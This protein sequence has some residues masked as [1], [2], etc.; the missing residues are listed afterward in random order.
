MDN[1]NVVDIPKMIQEYFWFRYL[2]ESTYKTYLMIGHLLN[3]EIRGEQ[4]SE[5]LMTAS[6][7]IEY[8]VGIM[9]EEKEKM[10]VKLGR[11][12]PE[13]RFED[14]NLLLSYN[15][16]SILNDEEENLVYVYNMPLP[17]PE[18]VLALDEEEI[19]TLNDIRFEFKHQ[20]VFNKILTLLIN[21]NGKVATSLDHI[22]NTTGA[23]HSD[24]KVVLQYLLEE[25]SIKIVAEKEVSE[26]RK[27]D[28][29]YID[30][31]KE[32]F[33]EKRFVIE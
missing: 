1:T 7:D 24:I 15:L 14:L 17:R 5:M 27:S 33:E 11:K 30:I 20:D 2:P 32:I 26:L 18:D 16:I 31:V 6:F 21:S 10:V 22:H 9:K 12:Y 29:V 28:K 25:G 13:N 4:A 8:E 3:E 19:Q 23:K